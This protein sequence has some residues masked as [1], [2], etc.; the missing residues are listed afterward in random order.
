MKRLCILSFA[1]TILA[2]LV[3]TGCSGDN[4]TTPSPA[5]SE[6]ARDRD[7]V[8]VHYTGTLEDGTKFDSSLDRGEPLTFVLG[9]GQMISGFDT[10]VHGMTV[11]EKKTV[12]LPPEQAYGAHDPD[13]VIMLSPD[14]FPADMTPYVGMQVP[15]QTATGQMFYG[16]VIQIT[17]DYVKVDVNHELAGKTL[18][19]EIELVSITPAS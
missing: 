9:A 5:A 4:A 12:T 18:V 8:S 16:K 7:T 10:A 11:G 6:P 2:L 19:F 17:P 13:R 1:I 3:T 14:E 15:L